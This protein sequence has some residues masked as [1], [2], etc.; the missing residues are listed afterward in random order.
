MVL[1]VL[2]VDGRGRRWWRGCRRS[3][4]WGLSIH[5]VLPAAGGCS[6]NLALMLLSAI[7]VFVLLAGILIGVVMGP[8][9][10]GACPRPVASALSR[11]LMALILAVPVVYAGAV[12]VTT[13]R[14]VTAAPAS[15]GGAVPPPAADQFVGFHIGL[16]AEAQQQRHPGVAQRIWMRASSRQV[17]DHFGRVGVPWRAAS[18]AA[19]RRAW[20]APAARGA[21]GRA[22]MPS[23]APRCHVAPALL[24]RTHALRLPSSS[25]KASARGAAS[26]G[27]VVA[28][29][30]VVEGVREAHA[31]CSGW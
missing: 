30:D 15:P 7:L 10:A 8:G 19:G 24:V 9:R 6:F 22:P 16:R 5:T 12:T 26:H 23:A 17:A 31:R 1:L 4:R 20:P 14:V 13:R 18:A 11:W 28:R 25:R 21:T 27:G 29:A 2:C 3:R